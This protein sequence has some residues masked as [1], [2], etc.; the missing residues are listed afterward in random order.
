MT[1]TGAVTITEYF[2]AAAMIVGACGMAWA[3]R[4]VIREWWRRISFQKPWVLA[5]AQLEEELDKHPP[6]PDW[7]LVELCNLLLG[8]N[9][10]EDLVWET[11]EKLEDSLSLGKLACWGVNTLICSPLKRILC[12]LSLK[13]IGWA[14]GFG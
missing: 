13:N 6:Q 3:V 10:T 11:K 1:V 2:G 4:F 7:P 8:P 9:E 12:S 5:P 14:T